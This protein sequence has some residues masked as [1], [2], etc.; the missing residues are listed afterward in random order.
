MPEPLNGIP[1]DPIGYLCLM[2]IFYLCHKLEARELKLETTSI[3]DCDVLRQQEL[4]LCC[5][6]Y[7]QLLLEY[8]I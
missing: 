3:M 7:C 2:S 5:L 8:M 6:S 1:G 4:V